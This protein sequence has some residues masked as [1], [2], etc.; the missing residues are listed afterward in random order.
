[1]STITK[2]EFITELSDVTGIK[3]SDVALMLECFM[4]LT[5]KH[6]ATGNEITLRNFGTFD[7]RVAKGKVG[8]N[9]KQPNSDI[10]IPDRCVVR[11][12]PCKELKTRVASVP[13][14]QVRHLNGN[15]THPEA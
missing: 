12:K 6:L 8:R 2:K 5:V 15:G 9:P 13:I 10:M 7:L 3:H 4:E 14:Q 11:F 1:M